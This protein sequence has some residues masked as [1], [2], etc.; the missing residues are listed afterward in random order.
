ME[1]FD[2]YQQLTKGEFYELLGRLA[3]F[4]FPADEYGEHYPLVRKLEQLIQLILSKL[5]R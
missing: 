4:L 3:H 5:V 2:R 1:D